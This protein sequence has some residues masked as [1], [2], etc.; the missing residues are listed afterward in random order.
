MANLPTVAV[1]TIGHYRHGKTT[2]TA[3]ITRVLAARSGAASVRVLDLDRRGGPA[4]LLDDPGA[5]RTVVPG[6]LRYSTEHRSFIHIDCPG[7]RPWLKNAARAQALADAAILVVSA[8]DSIQP[9]TREHLLLARALGVRQLVVFINKCDLIPDLE[10]ID[11]IE[12]D[13]RDM[14]DGLGFDGNGTRILRGAALPALMEGAG[15]PWESG[16]RDLIEAL[17]L[18]I[19]VPTHDTASPPLLYIHGAFDRPQFPRDVIV[20]GRLRRG[21][22]ARQDKLVLLGYGDSVQI[23]VEDIEVAHHKADRAEAGERVGLQLHSIDRALVARAIHAGQALVVREQAQARKDFRAR[24]Q[25]FSAAEGGRPSGIRPGHVAHVLF[26]TATVAGTIHPLP[27]TVVQP[28]ETADVVVSLRQPIYLESGMPFVIRDGNQ[29]VGWKRDV[30]ARWG[31][32]S[33][34]GTI[35]TTIS[36]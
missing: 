27:N 31:G 34:S 32:S 12:R 1:V 17:E 4:A 25:L 3:A 5:T 8:L 35:L 22:I 30:P 10:W 16:I 20:E 23:R 18:D 26:G 19:T 9:Q 15:S 24:L 36:P 33:G 11:L 13:V 7:H 14:L 2:L 29:G 28:G 21:V 6:H